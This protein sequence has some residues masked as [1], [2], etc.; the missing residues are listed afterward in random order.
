MRVAA[1]SVSAVAG[2]LIGG[3]ATYLTFGTSTHV[4]DPTG[5]A[6]TASSPTGDAPSSAAATA[7]MSAPLPTAER[8]AVYAYV[9]ESTEAEELEFLVQRT[10]A[11][12]IS[13]RRTFEL[14]A[15]LMRLAELDVRRA[16]RFARTLRL[17]TERLVPL[18]QSWAERDADA[19]LQELRRLDNA[20]AVREISLA[21]LDVLGDDERA[22]AQVEAVLAPSQIPAFRQDAAVR[23]ASRDPFRA[24]QRA[25]AL[26]DSASRTLAASR[27]ATEWA[28]HDPAAALALADTITDEAVRRS[29]RT[30]V[31]TEW[32][33]ID[34]DAVFG[35]LRAGR[36]T[37]DVTEN[38]TV[39]SSLAPANPEAVLELAEELPGEM[40]R[41]VLQLALLAMAERDPYAAI[42]RLDAMPSRRDRDQL[43]PA[44]AQA[45]AQRDPDGALEWAKSL[46]QSSPNVLMSVINGIATVDPHRAIDLI[47][48]E[49]FGAAQPSMLPMLV[50][51]STLAGQRDSARIAAIADRL[52]ASG[53]V[54]A[55]NQIGTL[56]SS[57]SRSDPDAALEWLLRNAERAGRQA[58]TQVAFQLAT[59]DPVAAA[60]IIDRL[61]PDFQ[62]DWLRSVAGGYAQYD[63]HAAATWILQY[64]GRPGFTESL[65]AIAPALAQVDPGAAAR[66]IE[67][68]DGW[69]STL[70]AAQVAASWAVSDP[71][72]A[73]NWAMQ[74]ADTT[75][76]STAL[77]SVVGSWAS[78]DLDGAQRWVLS[79]PRG[80]TRD[81]ALHRLLPMT[82]ARDSEIDTRLLDAFSNDAMRQNAV[83]SAAVTLAGR[84][85]EAA[86]R[87]VDQHVTNPQI[88]EQAYAMLDRA[89]VNVGRSGVTIGVVAPGIS[90]ATPGIILP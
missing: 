79:Q 87:L 78:E 70:A 77:S 82:V 30:A 73:A 26:D 84:D 69:Y 8:L 40:R 53:N 28:E 35:H 74:L 9:S 16:V 71:M 36:Y 65:A 76:R 64:E 25:V 90:T 75:M 12:P 32:A 59:D 2:A 66:M 80:E 86:R 60:G 7:P 17:E 85:R 50:V 14:D 10:A 38:L 47:L 55:V 19:A 33:R 88:R 67:R 63:A 68:L 57:W 11:L 6:L 48:D 1:L 37:G 4:A 20:V 61:P 41:V 22:L 3:A 21:L 15:L 13:H 62:G 58:I 18:F 54:D 72:A 39:F 46:Q 51:T 29:F 23:L 24:L 83:M 27:I 45:F 44:I 89:G 81:Q 31:L 42:A 5:F 43:L 56:M 34:P 52:V 49:S